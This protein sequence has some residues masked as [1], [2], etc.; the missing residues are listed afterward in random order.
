MGVLVD[1]GTR[2]YVTS[3]SNVLYIA[4]FFCNFH[5]GIQ[6]KCSNVDGINVNVAKSTTD[7][8]LNIGNNESDRDVMIFGIFLL[9]SIR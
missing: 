9:F 1:K 4:C 2:V 3:H 6:V 5:H 8:T 7:E